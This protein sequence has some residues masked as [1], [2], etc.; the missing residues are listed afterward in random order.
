MA[1]VIEESLRTCKKCK[2]KTI[3]I[4]NAKKTGALM[5]LVH[6]VLTVATMG[7]WIALVIV[8]MVLTA[9]IGGW[10]CKECST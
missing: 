5:I 6:I 2:K 9:K 8:W 10:T 7:I 4:R 3:H 1:T